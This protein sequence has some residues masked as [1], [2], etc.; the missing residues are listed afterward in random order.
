MKLQFISRLLLGASVLFF[1]SC[2][3]DLP[4]KND[5][6]NSSS[7]LSKAAQ[8]Q[9]YNTFYGHQV[10]LGDGK[11]RTFVTMSH[12]GV[13]T[14]V[15]IEMTAGALQGLGEEMIQLSF[16]FH[17]KAGE[18]TPFDHVLLD[19]NPEGHEPFFYEHPHFDFHF[20]TITEAER[21]AISPASP[22]MNQLPPF[23]TWPQGYVPTDG[24]VPQMGK[25]WV[26]PASPE[27]SGGQLFTH[28]MIYGSYAGN[29]I[30]VEP[31]ITRA[32]LLSGQT[33][34]MPYGQPA[35]FMITDTY[36]PTKYNIYKKDGKYYVTL[37]D[38]VWRS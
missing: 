27:I 26:N 2:Q 37:T 21:L 16:P 31:M 34:S 17:K 4:S 15:G 23:P 24:G 32:F 7:D 36:H 5:D 14:V 3:K 9:K 25:H 35:Q 12:T 6:L 20:Y 28:T 29:F 11:V 30:F 38:F 10:H 19:W 8:A 33:V 22:L 18:V 13:P 1:V